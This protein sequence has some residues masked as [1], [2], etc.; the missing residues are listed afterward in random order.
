MRPF[1]DPHSAA[2]LFAIHHRIKFMIAELQEHLSTICVS[3]GAIKKLWRGTST[4][5][6]LFAYARPIRLL[7]ERGEIPAIRDNC[8]PIRLR[9]CAAYS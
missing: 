7:C 9:R 5:R 1:D 3:R 8:R 4:K 6:E 2:G